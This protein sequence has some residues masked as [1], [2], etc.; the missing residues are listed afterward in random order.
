MNT[1]NE[2]FCPLLNDKIDEYQCFEVHCVVNR[3]VKPVIGP[4]KAYEK[5]NFREVCLNCPKHRFD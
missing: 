2:Y 3:E 5:E 4:P 1:K